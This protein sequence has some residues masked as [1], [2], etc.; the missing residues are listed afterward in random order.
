M[1]DGALDPV[2]ARAGGAVTGME[3]LRVLLVDDS[4]DDAALVARE[5]EA[6]GVG[7]TTARV[8]TVGELE[9]AL[10]ERWDVI[11]SDYSLC[12][13]D[14]TLVLDLVRER[15]PDTPVLV[16]SGSI[17]EE[18]AV[19]IMRRGAR[20]FL[21]KDR[22]HRLSAAVLREVERSR[23]NSERRAA[24][25]ELT[26]IREAL[27]SELSRS[28]AFNETFTGVL[29][30]DLRNPLNTIALASQLLLTRLPVSSRELPLVERISRATD[31]MR[32]MIDQLLDFTRIRVG[33]GLGLD[34]AP[35]DLARICHQAVDEL[36][37]EGGP[38]I[39]LEV[40]G[41]TEGEWDADRL[42][43]LVSN[44]TAN[45][46]THGSPTA[47]IRVSVDGTEAAAVRL[48]VQNAGQIPEAVLP[49][50]FEPLHPS[51]ASSRN[52]AQ[53]LGLGLFIAERIAA[54]H[55][56]VVEVSSNA[57]SGTRF[58]VLLPR[59]PLPNEADKK[60]KLTSYR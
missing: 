57:E 46:V 37:R 44:L 5:L 26:E 53:G 2:W 19:E 54:A 39:E 13:F 11:V 33:P 29:G 59:A 24:D 31:R 30:H 38:E 4:A 22:L 56:A 49:F 12:G 28:V 25:A 23:I 51:K 47:P 42:L 43:Q 7:I 14:A 6:G 58:A 18:S 17:G 15:S 40:R 34:R 1:I 21:L 35:C 48:S 52:R 36:L 3:R 50:L 10:A 16:V 41:Q 45:A 20:D 9:A 27:L 32:R 8:E 60:S 55:G